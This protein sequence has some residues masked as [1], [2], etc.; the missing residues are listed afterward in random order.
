MHYCLVCGFVVPS[1]AVLRL[2]STMFLHLNPFLCDICDLSFPNNL[3]L[4]EVSCQYLF[5]GYV[6]IGNYFQHFSSSPR[7]PIYQFLQ[8]KSGV[9][10]DVEAIAE[11][12]QIDADSELNVEC[13]RCQ[14]R[15]NNAGELH[16]HYNIS[17]LHHWCFI[18]NRYFQLPG[19]LD[20][21]G[22]SLLAC[23]TIAI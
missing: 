4:H 6:L 3:A 11:T 10:Y 22:Q 17:P 16:D 13:S 2:H 7:H 5:Q 23:Y 9:P 18:C 14:L 21:V 20:A 12:P 15:F 19:S 1:V 8:S